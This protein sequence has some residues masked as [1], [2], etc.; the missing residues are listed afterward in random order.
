MDKTP[1]ETFFK[2]ALKNITEYGDT[3]IFPFPIE[4]RIFFDKQIDCLSLLGDIDKNY[5]DRITTFP[6]ANVT[7]LAPV[8]YTGFRWA[9]QLDPLWNAYFLGLVL[10]A[11]DELE[12]E[13]IPKEKE[14]VFS[15]RFDSNPDNAALFDTAY[16]WRSFMEK[17][18]SIAKDA[19][20][21]VT[22]DIS[23][24][25]PR[26]NHHRLENA[27]LQL[28]LQPGTTK[29]IMSFLKNFS[30]TYSFGLPV[31][32][33]ASR[34]L[35]ELLLNRIDRLLLAEGISF[36]RFADD[37]HLFADS[38]EGAF[39]SL[40]YLSDRLLDTQGLQLQKSKTRIMAGTEFIATS[41]LQL[42]SEDPPPEGSPP[43]LHEQSQA[44]LK[45]SVRFDPYSPTAAEDYETLK[46]ELDKIDIVSLLKAELTKS[47]IHI[48]L[49]KKIVSAIRF[50]DEPQRSEAVL[51]LIDDAELLYPIYGNILQTATFLYDELSPPYQEKIIEKVRGLIKTN[52]HTVETDLNLS[53]AIRLLAKKS[54]PENE[55]TL[56]KSY[57][58]SRS[59]LIRR[60][61]ILIM[62]KWKASYWLSNLRS[63]FRT[64]GPA[65]RRSFII[66]SHSLADEGEHWRRNI[67]KELSPFEL[68]VQ[69]WANEKAKLESW[70]LPT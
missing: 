2:R 34:L 9:T 36:C 3:D 6:P 68:I 64:L 69:A 11:S 1:M 50:I 61:I 47:R 19:K 43:N 33:P 40:L 59:P 41:P 30:D 51:S 57:D 52:S 8:G 32:G 4:N 28:S 48:S 25:Y 13:R 12:K 45:L 55:E 67:K 7:T 58:R 26:L 24:F 42:T 44:L 62:A 63:S 56:H 37:F 53:Y 27:L 35:S 54:V 29:K 15:Y 14:V 22:C 38:Y 23:E 17:S 21:V 18:I 70:S 10:S 66:A 31:G 20:F 39:K 49:S 65:E 60:D 46:A 16:N 5:F